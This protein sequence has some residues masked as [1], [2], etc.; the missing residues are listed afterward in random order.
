MKYEVIQQTSYR[1]TIKNHQ[2][3]VRAVSLIRD[4]RPGAP[5]GNTLGALLFVI[6]D[7]IN[8]TAYA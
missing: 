3:L 8:I 7:V 2:Q 6:Y 5:V 4:I 1:P